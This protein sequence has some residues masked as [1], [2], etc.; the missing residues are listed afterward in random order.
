MALCLQFGSDDLLRVSVREHSIQD[1]LQTHHLRV[2]S[3]ILLGLG[4][5]F[6]ILMEAMLLFNGGQFHLGIGS[7][8]EG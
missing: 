2:R 1:I 5:G 7:G 8:G 6:G 3:Y 4:L